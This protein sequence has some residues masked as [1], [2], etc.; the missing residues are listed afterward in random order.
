MERSW[1]NSI[2]GNVRDGM[3]VYATDNGVINNLNEQAAQYSW[4]TSDEDLGWYNEG[5][6]RHAWTYCDERPCEWHNH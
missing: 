3:E 4:S 2:M 1:L 6:V 5:H